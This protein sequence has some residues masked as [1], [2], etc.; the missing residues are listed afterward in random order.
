[1]EEEVTMDSGD[2]SCLLLNI[3]IHIYTRDNFRSSL[4][5]L[6]SSEHLSSEEKDVKLI[7]GTAFSSNSDSENPESE[8]IRIMRVEE[9]M[10]EIIPTAGY[11]HGLLH[12]IQGHRI[13][14]S[15]R[16]PS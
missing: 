9:P 16:E 2:L 13:R 7:S 5:G 1:M 4:S 11:Q 10:M 15:R 6:T 14:S 12:Q 8:D 3:H